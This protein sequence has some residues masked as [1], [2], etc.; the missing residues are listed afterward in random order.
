M[1]DFASHTTAGGA[2]VK[3]TKFKQVAL[4]LLSAGATG[5]MYLGLLY[6]SRSMLKINP[7]ISVSIAYAGAMAFYFVTNKLV[8]F[9]KSKSGSVWREL[10]GFLP[11]VVVNY[12][13][14]L[15]IVAFIRQFTNEE[16]SGSLVAGIVTTALAYFVFEKW[17][18]KKKMVGAVT[19]GT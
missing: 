3:E 18:F 4:F 11:R 16:Y 7:Y 12:I 8:V 5:A 19:P 2:A 10:L 9:K 14:T 15:S 1:Q 13:L 17:L 6:V